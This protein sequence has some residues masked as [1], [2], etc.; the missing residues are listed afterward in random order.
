MSTFP[1][2]P[3]SQARAMLAEASA[4]RKD[5]DAT[6][7][8]LT[9]SIR[10]LDAEIAA[11]APAEAALARLDAEHSAAFGAWAQDP[12]LPK[13]EIDAVRREAASV[14][15][16]N[17][18]NSAA[19]AANAKTG[20]EAQTMAAAQKIAPIEKHINAAVAEVVLETAA[21]L[22]DELIAEAKALTARA[23]SIEQAGMLALVT[24]ESVNDPH[25]AGA[26]YR[27]LEAF[28][29]KFRDARGAMPVDPELADVSRRGWQ[30]FA[31]DLREDS[32][33]SVDSKA[34][35]A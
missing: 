31:A 8:A 26:V 2:K 6:I 35:L 11:V 13:P 14:A 25:V 34:V 27:A 9:A 10:R 21:P 29:T 5:A 15:L 1:T 32:A 23:K 7:A 22:I 12:S 20:L 19:A 33:V 17:A 3:V 4:A 28:N 24:A 18:R 16:A 30:N